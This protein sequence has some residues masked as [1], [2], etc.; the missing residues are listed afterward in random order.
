MPGSA[1]GCAFCAI[2]SGRAEA[3]RVLEDEL[4]VAFLDRRPLF[5]GHVLL[6]PREHHTVLGE[7]PE[8]LVGP[9][10]AR[11]GRLARALERGLGA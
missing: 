3:A 9:L 2:A 4:A 7:L 6:I 5:P 10:F 11:A 8:P 1:A